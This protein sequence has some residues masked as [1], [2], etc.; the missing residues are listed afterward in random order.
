MAEKILVIGA[1]GLL[2]E[3]VARK[4]K[5]DGYTVRILSRSV[6]KAKAKYG[7]NF[8]IAVG[9]VEDTRTLEAALRNCDGVHI[10]LD[11]GQD[12]D[13]ERRGVINIVE[14][15][16][17]VGVKRLTYLSGA[18]VCEENRW[19]AGTN[20]K[21]QAEAAITSSGLAYTIFKATFFIESLPRFVQGKRASV[22]GKQ[23]SSWHW[24]SAVDY[25]EMVSK[26]YRSSEVAGKAIYV[27]GPEAYTL[28]NALKI[29]C[30]TFSPN[31]AVSNL[32][33]GMARLIALMSG[34]KEL[35][36]V[37]PFF[38]Y[39]GKVRENGDSNAAKALLGRPFITLEEWCK[40]RSGELAAS[41]KA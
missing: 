5:A 35:K 16:K 1:T 3:P 34:N 20:A 7:A 41:I 37:L 9:D 36:Q 40:A 19:F 27:L 33:M 11:G 6:E 2:G 23:P 25:A 13:L 39:T 26:A 8:E 38:N 10:N 24:V 21:Y 31:T 29:Y 28:E 17:K 14:A 15:A 18:S 32:P 30:G 12:P 22:I 4:L